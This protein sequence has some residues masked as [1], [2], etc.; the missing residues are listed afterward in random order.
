M[1]LRTLSHLAL[2]V[3]FYAM[4]IEGEWVQGM[5]FLG[6]S[7]GLTFAHDV[8]HRLEVIDGRLKSLAERE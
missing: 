6:L 1:R 5:I 3:A 4:F 8:F 7:L 2:L